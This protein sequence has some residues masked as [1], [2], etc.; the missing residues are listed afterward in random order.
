MQG[1]GVDGE[2]R[3]IKVEIHTER[4]VQAKVKV[5]RV[6]FDVLRLVVVPETG[7]LGPVRRTVRVRR[8]RIRH[9]GYVGEMMVL[10]REQ[11]RTTLKVAT[12]I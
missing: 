8:A 7:E 12:R 5:T 11:N 1:T 10:H 3:G 2:R 4:V 6:E 9:C